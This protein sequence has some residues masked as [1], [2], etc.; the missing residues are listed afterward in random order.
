MP[1]SKTVRD[2]LEELCTNP[3]SKYWHCVRECT[4]VL[5]SELRDL[6]LHEGEDD[7]R[8]R[9][10]GR[11][12]SMDRV[13]EKLDRD[14]PIKVSTLDELEIEVD[15]IVGAR[16]V[17]DYIN[18]AEQMATR[19]EQLERW[20][21]VKNEPASHP[22]GYSAVRHIDVVLGLDRR[23]SMQSEIQIRTRLQEA[24]GIWSHPIYVFMRNRK[25]KQPPQQ[26]ITQLRS[27]SG[28]LQV[29]DQAA[30][31][32]REEFDSWKDRIS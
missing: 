24:W 6:G 29:A 31:N 21:I 10:S 4:H 28:A 23:G 12:K 18:H 2:Q 20:E 5:R 22:T 1:A 26:I 8:A 25:F 7:V 32:L 14:G 19:L 15:D 27:I 3:T 30:D 17:L 9:V 11:V 16:V 13:L